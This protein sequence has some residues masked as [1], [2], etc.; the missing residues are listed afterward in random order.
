MI[1]FTLYYFTG[2]ED[3]PNLEKFDT[4]VYPEYRSRILMHQ[5][6]ASFWF[7]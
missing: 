2:K 6:F 4:P 3:N 1:Y 7:E 5:P